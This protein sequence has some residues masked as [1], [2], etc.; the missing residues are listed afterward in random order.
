[1]RNTVSPSLFVLLFPQFVPAPG[2]TAAPLRS[3]LMKQRIVPVPGVY[4]ATSQARRGNETINILGKT[5]WAV[6]TDGCRDRAGGQTGGQR[7]RREDG[8]LG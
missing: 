2:T 7:R 1:M 6:A 8:L 4:K 5:E 3:S